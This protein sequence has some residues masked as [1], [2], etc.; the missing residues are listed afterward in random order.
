MSQEK[1][2]TKSEIQKMAIQH[3]QEIKTTFAAA[4]AI[5]MLYLFI[6]PPLA[7]QKKTTGEF[8]RDKITQIDNAFSTSNPNYASAFIIFEQITAC[9]KILNNNKSIGKTSPEALSDFKKAILELPT[10]A[11]KESILTNQ[12][13]I[14]TKNTTECQK[15]L[16][17]IKETL[18]TRSTNTNINFNTICTILIAL[19][20]PIFALLGAFIARDQK[21][22]EFRQAWIDR[23][24][25]Y[26]KKLES[27]EPKRVGA[28]LREFRIELNE[29]NHPESID[30]RLID[31]ISYYEKEIN[32]KTYNRKNNEKLLGNIRQHT[33]SAIKQ[34][35]EIIKHG[36]LTTRI[37]RHSIIIFTLYF[38]I[39]LLTINHQTTQTIIALTL[40]SFIYYLLNRKIIHETAKTIWSKATFKNNSKQKN[41]PNLVKTI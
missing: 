40:T 34:E 14:A 10:T 38:F 37:T 35:W 36:E 16:G 9:E 20:V 29:D 7:A 19:F 25:E 18:Q 32:N 30:R 4:A 26:A 31:A 1:S 2:S 24:R 11:S 41:N 39:T 13:N 28:T 15:E 22:A 8:I 27:R 23:I 17:T 3:S 6:N 33:K 5:A 12:L 21:I